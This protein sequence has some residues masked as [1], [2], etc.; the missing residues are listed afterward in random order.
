MPGVIHR[1][2][3]CANNL[4]ACLNQNHVRSEMHGDALLLPR[5]P[6]VINRQQHRADARQRQHHDHVRGMVAE[7][8]ADQLF[9]LDAK[10]K[11]MRRSAAHRIRQRRVGQTQ[12]AI[13][14]RRRIR[15]GARVLVLRRCKVH[16]LYRRSAL[17]RNSF[18]STAGL[19]LSASTSARVRW[20]S[21][22]G[23]SVPKITLS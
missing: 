21:S 23:K 7:R 20:K 4:R 2:V 17:S 18:C 16:S 9:A 8:D 5:R 1:N 6:A 10:R 12:C 13:D 3:R 15:P 14:Q 19:K 22:T 11:Q